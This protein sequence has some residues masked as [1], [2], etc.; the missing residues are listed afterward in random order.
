MKYELINYFDVWGNA[1]DGWEVNNQ[2]VEFRDLIITEDASDKDILNYLVDIGFLATSDM[3]KLLV[4]NNGDM[5]EIFEKKSMEAY[6][7]I[8][9]KFIIKGI[10]I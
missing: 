7:R 1:E 9:D 10:L 3:R 6:M 2:C 4:D 8:G 5:I